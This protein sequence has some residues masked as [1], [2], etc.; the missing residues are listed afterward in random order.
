MQVRNRNLYLP[1]I[2]Y[3]FDKTDI[4]YQTGVHTI[5]FDARTY[6]HNAD[7]VTFIRCKLKTI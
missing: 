2:K 3:H 7:V 1:L 5:A 4:R 6:S